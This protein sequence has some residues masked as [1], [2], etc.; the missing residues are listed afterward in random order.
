MTQTKIAPNFR[1]T[2][3]DQP[4]DSVT[5][6]PGL[7]I[8]SIDTELAW[9]IDAQD[10]PRYSKVLDDEP[11]IIRRLIGLLDEHQ[12]PATWALVGQLL[13]AP[14]DRREGGRTPERWYYAP[15][16]LE[17][18]NN[19]RVRHEVGTHT[20]SHVCAHDVSTTRELWRQELEAAAQMSM[21]HGITMRSIVYPRNQ[22]A[23]TDI[24]SDFGIIAYRGVEQ[25]W[26]GNHH[27]V[28]HF[29]DR[30]LGVASPTY[31]LRRLREGDR[32]VN[33]PASQFLM[34]DNGM[35]KLIPPASRIRQARL[36]L[37]RATRRGELY[38][39]WFHPFNLGGDGRM[40]QTLDRIL[41]DIS[42]RRD[43]GEIAVM[44]MGQTADLVLRGAGESALETEG[45]P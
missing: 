36:A 44:T 41:R 39:L 1:S 26:Y 37:D 23:H 9:G 30:A 15:R 38:H 29:V 43:R 14:E 32:L 12:I 21:R 42:E 17:W 22:V 2:E 16:L 25:S 31:D 28:L 3:K 45:R 7:C 5:G 18:I 35:R 20:F 34:G 24:L 10:L 40:F 19:A 8:L 11:I 6:M 27:G 33:L 13:M 4:L